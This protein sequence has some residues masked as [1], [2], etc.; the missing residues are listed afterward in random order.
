MG[1]NRC[2]HHWWRRWSVCCFRKWK[3][4]G[5]SHSSIVALFEPNG[6]HWLEVVRRRQWH[7]LD[8]A[9]HLIAECGS[10]TPMWASE[11]SGVLSWHRFLMYHPCLEARH[12]PHARV[13]LCKWAT[14]VFL[15]SMREGRWMEANSY[16]V[17]P[18]IPSGTPTPWASLH[19][20]YVPQLIHLPSSWNPAIDIPKGGLHLSLERRGQV[21]GE[22]P[23]GET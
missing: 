20:S 9:H 13:V 10:R 17:P 2:S 16:V 7:G 3:R 15:V 22:F 12:W 8:V 23:G 18:C 14:R 5:R 4:R 21:T 6:W 19:V 11:G 1:L